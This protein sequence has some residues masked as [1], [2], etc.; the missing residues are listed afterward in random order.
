M[1]MRAPMHPSIWSQRSSSL[2]R[3]A[4][5]G[6][7]SMAPVLTEPA[8]AITQQGAS[9]SARSFAMAAQRFDVYSQ[10]TVYRNAPQ[11]SI[12]EAEC[13]YRLAM[14]GMNL[15]RSVEAQGLFDRCD[16]ELAHVHARLDVTCDRQTD[17]VR[18]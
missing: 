3:A 18:H 4:S 5:A 6:K 12:A 7:S 13:L 14:T 16:T 1:A 17:D 8:V 9:P 2:A 15:V 10:R 11:R